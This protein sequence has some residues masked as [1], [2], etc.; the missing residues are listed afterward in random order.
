MNTEWVVFETDARR[1]QLPVDTQPSLPRGRIESWAVTWRELIHNRLARLVW[2]EAIRRLRFWEL[3]LR[4]SRVKLLTEQ[5][6]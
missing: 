1:L 6:P 3:N 5:R 4:L 2:D